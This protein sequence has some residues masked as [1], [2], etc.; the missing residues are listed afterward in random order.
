MAINAGF[1]FVDILPR[2]N[3][4][5]FQAAMNSQLAPA[6]TSSAAKVSKGFADVFKKALVPIGATAIA[7]STIAVGK[8][9]L[10]FEDAFT[11]IAAIS[12]ASA[13]QIAQWRQQVFALGRETA[14]APQELADGLFYLASAGLKATQIFPALEAS[15]K[16]AAVGLGEMSELTRITANV[17]NAYPEAGLEAADA[18]DVLVAAVREGT[19]EPEEFA[20]AIGRLLPIASKAGVSFDELAASLSVLS[21][22]GLDVDEGVTGVRQVLNLIVSP[23]K[24]ATETMTELGL[25]TEFLRDQLREEGIL[26]VLR[27]LEERTKGNEDAMRKLLPNIRAMTAAFGLTEQEAAKVDAI[28]RRVANSS[29]DLDKAFEETQAGPGFRF[30][31]LFERLTEVAIRFGQVLLP[32]ARGIAGAFLLIL[33]PISDLL[34][35]LAQAPEAITAIAIAFAAWTAIRFVPRLLLLIADG[36]LKISAA[37]LGGRILGML[38]RLGTALETL[39]AVPA[40]GPVAIG[41]TA[42]TAGL[43]ALHEANQANAI[44]RLRDYKQEII[45]FGRFH[46]EAADAVKAVREEVVSFE[47]QRVKFAQAS[48]PIHERYGSTVL[49][50]QGQVDA[51]AERE[52]DRLE[53]LHDARAI[54][55]AD[56]TEIQEALDTIDLGQATRQLA[57]LTEQPFSKFSAGLQEALAAGQT[58]MGKWEDFVEETVE[59]ASGAFDKFQADVSE[60]IGFVTPA[61]EELSSA[62]TSAQEELAAGTDATGDAL[63]ELRDDAAL[64]VAEVFDVMTEKR[65]DMRDFA[66]DLLDIS[67]VGGRAGE[68]AAQAILAMG[69]SG[70][71]LADLFSD[72][73]TP[74]QRER[75]VRLFSEIGREQED[76]AT[77][78]TRRLLGTMKQIR[79]L[80]EDIAVGFGLIPDPDIDTTEAQTK[81][82]LLIARMREVDGTVVQATAIVTVERREGGTVPVDGSNGDGVIPDRGD[83]RARGGVI[84]AQHGLVV[85]R[86]ILVGEGKY[87]TPFGQGSEAILPLDDA[88]IGRLGASMARHIEIPAIVVKVGE[89]ELARTVTR[90]QRRRRS[91]VGA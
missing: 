67:K 75:F 53:D 14:I 79:E 87:A 20:D 60:S 39:A 56:V 22:I 76:L 8:L 49:K 90:G 85:R 58:D 26:S 9:T 54:R 40:L 43:V 62:A 47:R 82:D 42:L 17:L 12:N 38:G 81:L 66:R 36:L 25:A 73:A 71:A 59:Q 31:Q 35:L 33:T 86:P 89:E 16:A 51:A 78:L 32:V 37:F 13:E 3:A 83:F 27:T 15:A 19:A 24:Q 11:R 45:D 57:A 2:V 68:Q 55:Q 5:A 52:L 1:G 44:K 21:N 64:T 70:Q 7:A 34:A 61:L 50:V 10:A 80:L 41:V 88:T 72:A 18:I 63:A 77:Q 28:F 74:E 91:L 46:P 30:R 65:R 69:E 84:P 29:G 4:A 48:I 23:G 6:A